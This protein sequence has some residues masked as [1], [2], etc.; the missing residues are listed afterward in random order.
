MKTLFPAQQKLADHFVTRH[1]AGENTLDTSDL[2]T[3]KT[4]VACA[5][6]TAWLA[7]HCL[8]RGRVA[9]IC[10]KSA[11]GNW[12]RELEEADIDPLF[13]LNPEKLRTGNT[14]WVK[15]LG[16]K[17]MRWNLPS[18]TLVIVDE[19]HWAK[20][21]FTQNAQLVISLAQQKHRLHMLSATAAEDPTQMRALGYALGLHSLVVSTPTLPNWYKWMMA[22][23]C[24]QNIWN[25]WE[26]V[27][28]SKL[29]DLH[30]ALYRSFGAPAGRLSVADLPDA[31][32][33]NRIIIEP[34]EFKGIGKVRKAY[35]D[36]GI[37]PE[38]VERL[39]EDGT[40]ENSEWALV[41]ILR[42]RQLAESLKAPL[43]MEVADDLLSQGFSVPI[44]VNFEETLQALRAHFKCPVI[45]GKQSATE[46]QSAIDRFQADD[47][48]VL[49]INT[50]AGGASISLHDVRGKHPRVSLISPGFSAIAFKQCTGRIF[51]NGA[52]SDAVQKVLVAKDSVEETVIRAILRKLNKLEL[53]H[54]GAPT[55]LK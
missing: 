50:A 33:E 42:A 37:T 54:T 28:Q 55:E 18:Q 23:G 9:V 22:N 16:K 45:H 8:S 15:K 49:V 5:V 19:I 41:N 11:M 40:V 6:A 31:F 17:I 7:F 39:I 52:K 12:R 20:A 34:V 53:L 46:R 4:V 44:F 32:K 24:E 2:G 30:W 1:L 21:P 10:P 43:F 47:V 3:G 29:S 25:A 51:R 36:L 38:I 26:F 14:E 27:D 48:R 13:I 35:D